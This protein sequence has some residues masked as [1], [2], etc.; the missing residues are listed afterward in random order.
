MKKYNKEYRK[1]HRKKLNQEKKEYY[2][3]HKEHWKQRAKEY[4][5]T[6]FYKENEKFWRLKY[7]YNLSKKR[8]LYLIKNGCI[9]CGINDIVDVHHIDGNWHNNKSLNLVC[10]CSKCHTLLHKRSELKTL[11]KLMDYFIN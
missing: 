3:K 5:K 6:D 8:Y 9:I 11:E 2:E 7:R 4:R 1:K 10:L